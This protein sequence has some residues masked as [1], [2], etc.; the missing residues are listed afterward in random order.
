MIHDDRDTAFVDLKTLL[1]EYSMNFDFAESL[2]AVIENF[3]NLLA[4]SLMLLHSLTGVHSPED[5]VIKGS[6]VHLE[7]LTKLM[8]TIWIFWQSIE[9]FQS[10]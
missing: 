6:S 9:L 2:T 5:V 4:E 8:Y 7:C 3:L 1:R 10:I